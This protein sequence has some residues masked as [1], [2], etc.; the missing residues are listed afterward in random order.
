MARN[1]LTL[2]RNSDTAD[3]SVIKIRNYTIS[4]IAVFLLNE[5]R[6]YRKENSPPFLNLL[7]SN[8]INF[9]EHFHKTVSNLGLRY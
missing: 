5:T 2:F 3:V 9:S 6:N 7:G 1:D 4:S 8:Q